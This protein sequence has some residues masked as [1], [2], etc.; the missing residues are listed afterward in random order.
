M[1]ANNNV[2]KSLV[3]S[4]VQAF[5][6]MDGLNEG[7]RETEVTILGLKLLRIYLEDSK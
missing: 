7:A 2:P 3:Q 1:Q 4:L 5:T 6:V